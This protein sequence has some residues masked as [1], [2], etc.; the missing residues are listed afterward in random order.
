[1]SCRCGSA[2]PRGVHPFQTPPF[3][4]LGVGCFAGSSVLPACC[5]GG[6]QRGLSCRRG[7]AQS[8][9][10]CPRKTLPITPHREV[11][12]VACSS[13]SAIPRW[14]SRASMPGADK[15][16]RALAGLLLGFLYSGDGSCAER[17]WRPVQHCCAGGLAKRTWPACACLLT[18]W[19]AG[20]AGAR[21]GGVAKT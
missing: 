4:T 1:M 2:L 14:R 16:W 8:R 7:S 9:C 11:G 10:T 20:G 18:W 5:H 17:S 19:A 12:C 3:A 6:G 13:P 15:I 21:G